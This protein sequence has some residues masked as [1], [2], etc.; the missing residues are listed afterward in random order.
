MEGRKTDEERAPTVFYS[1]LPH[2]IPS[3]SLVVNLVP[4]GACQRRLPEDLWRRLN[5]AEEGD[6]SPVRGDNND[7]SEKKKNTQLQFAVVSCQAAI[8]ADV[9]IYQSASQLLLL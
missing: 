3:S 4:A 9:V 7:T 8:S 1:S 6:H 5:D 2:P